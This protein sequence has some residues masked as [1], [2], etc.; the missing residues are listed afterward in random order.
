MLNASTPHR[1][2]SLDIAMS[3]S[4]EQHRMVDIRLTNYT[5]G[6]YDASLSIYLRCA[7]VDPTL[8]DRAAVRMAEHISD[9][10]PTIGATFVNARRTQHNAEQW[11]ADVLEACRMLVAEVIEADGQ[12]VP[13]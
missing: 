9:R 4:L 10:C 8:A 12:E 3:C 6:T 7:V 5:G 1:P 13:A 11:Q 2:L